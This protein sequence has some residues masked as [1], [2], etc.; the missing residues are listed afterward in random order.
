MK[1]VQA[2]LENPFKVDGIT[3]ITYTP[4][5]DEKIVTDPETGEM[6]TMRKLPKS[7]QH[8]HDGKVYVKLFQESQETLLKLPHVSIKILI[9]AMCKIRPL[10][11][12]V[13]LH[14]DDCMVAC[15]FKSATS[16]REG[17]K[18]LIKHNV[19]ARKMGSTMEYWVNPNIF[20]NGNRIRLASAL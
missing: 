9:Y 19:L 12:I 14:V 20:F 6:F 1:S 16:Y 15:G 5:V 8:L 17:I 10:S 18:I 7:Q 4:K 3:T 11:E 2:F 13:F